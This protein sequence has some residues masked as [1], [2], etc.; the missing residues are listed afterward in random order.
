MHP[1]L[2]W[3]DRAARPPFSKVSC[4]PFLVQEM[5]LQGVSTRRV[6]SITQALSRVKGSRD[7][8]SRITGK[9]DEEVTRWRT[10][11]ISQAFPYL[12][13]D[14]CYLKIRWGDRVGDLALLVA[15]G[16]SEDGYREVLAVESAAGE[17]KEAY[18]NMLKGLLER[19]LS[20]VQ[21]V[22]SDDHEAI[23]FAVGAEL[24]E[25]AW[26][27]CVV[28]FERIDHRPSGVGWDGLPVL[29]DETLRDEVRKGYPGD[30]SA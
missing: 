20:G 1:D 19:G 29:L 15:V 11:S 28:H 30:L 3:P 25:A 2:A 12:I 21:L 17:R 7:A 13:L 22:V 5:Y 10:R 9:L 16:V 26:Q 14:A 8:V 4:S 24:P 23:T 27:R 18:R 6:S